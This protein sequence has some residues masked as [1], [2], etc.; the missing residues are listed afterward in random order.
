MQHRSRRLLVVEDSDDLR[1]SLILLLQL[2]GHQVRGAPNGS[3]AL[4]MAREDPPEVALIDIG[5]PDIDGCE[6]ARRLRALPELDSVELV[7]LTGFAG[8]EVEQ[9]CREAGFT[10][11][12]VKPV[13]IEAL[14]RLLA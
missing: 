12:L 2:E 1:E 13:E 9:R 10:A 7:A 14:Q 3:G 6:L 11:H 4:E 5:L 8:Q